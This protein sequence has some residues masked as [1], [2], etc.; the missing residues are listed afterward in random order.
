MREERERCLGQG[1][2]GFLG[3]PFRREELLAQVRHHAAKRRSGPGS[4]GAPP[5]SR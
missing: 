5:R 1:F 4:F 3:K 2:D